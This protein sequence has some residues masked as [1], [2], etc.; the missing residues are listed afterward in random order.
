MDKIGVLNSKEMILVY[1]GSAAILMAVAGTIFWTNK[2]LYLC[3]NNSDVL[4]YSRNFDGSEIVEKMHESLKNSL[5]EKSSLKK[6]ESLE[7]CYGVKFYTCLI[8]ETDGLNVNIRRHVERLTNYIF[9]VVPYE[10]INDISVVVTNI[11]DN[12]IGKDNMYISKYSNL[13]PFVTLKGET[14]NICNNIEE[15]CSDFF[16]KTRSKYVLIIENGR[17]G[18]GLKTAKFGKF[19]RII[20]KKRT[21]KLTEEAMQEISEFLLQIKSV[22]EKY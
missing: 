7:L 18:L 11:S 1:F 16:A 15:I 22:I 2:P 3:A 10:R 13:P 19:N 5:Y 17:I 14:E 21:K 9:S 12:Y 4:K 8:R 6:F 20:N